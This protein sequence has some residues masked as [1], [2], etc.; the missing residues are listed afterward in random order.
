M[1][2]LTEIDREPFQ[3]FGYPLLVL[4][5]QESFKF[6]AINWLRSSRRLSNLDAARSEAEFFLWIVWR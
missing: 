2:L 5:G 1:E 4:K 6:Y 3:E